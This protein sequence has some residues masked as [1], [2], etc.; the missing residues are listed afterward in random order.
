MPE[1]KRAITL[2]QLL[3]HSSGIVDLEGEDD[4]DPIGREEFVRRIFAQALTFAPGTGY[5]YSNAGYSLLGAVIER[6]TGGSYERFV[7]ERLLLPSGLY[8]TGYVLAGF[9][10]ERMAQGYRGAEKWGTTLE[11]PL[12]EDGPFWVLRANGGLHTTAYD[13]LRWAEALRAGRVLA[14]ASRDLLW[15]P[16][17]R[18]G[19]DADTSYGYGWVVEE[20]EGMRVVTHNGGNGI[21]FA[22]LALVPDQGIVVFLQTNVV[23]G[24]PYVQRLLGQI[25]FR[26]AAGR[27]Y[28]EVPRVVPADPARLAELAGDWALAGRGRLRA[29]A[30]ADALLLEPLDPEAFASLLS[31]APLEPAARALGGERNRRLA[32]A[33]RALL[34]S[35]YGP[36]HR[37][38]GDAITIERLTAT[39][40]ERLAGFSERHGAPRAAEVLG[41]ARREERDFTVVRFRFERGSEDVAFVWDVEPEGRLRGISIGGL[42]PRLRFRGEAAGGYAAWDPRSGESVPLR[43]EGSGPAARLHIGRGERAAVAVR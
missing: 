12:A 36:L 25:G 38:Y 27:P 2:H 26:M 20:V 4:W 24:N 19:E 21:H 42:E 10:A 23:A 15:T 29:T 3:T 37:L 22:D 39:W 40:A 33:V 43:V 41:T 9:G 1:D 32:A 6:L 31:T 35:D 5:E 28:P 34:A 7:R 11:R 30:E 16:H 18:E 13:M 14:A 8:E 17:V